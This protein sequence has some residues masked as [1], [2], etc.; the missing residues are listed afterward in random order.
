ML[1]SSTVQSTT[2]TAE[3]NNSNQDTCAGNTGEMYSQVRFEADSSMVAVQMKDSV[4]DNPAISARCS[5]ADGAYQALH[6]YQN[7]PIK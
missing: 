1:I 5:N 4:C 6:L 2:E 7:T 3:N